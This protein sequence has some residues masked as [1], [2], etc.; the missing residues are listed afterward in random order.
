[1]P[2]RTDRELLTERVMPHVC[3]IVAEGG[4]VAASLRRV[5]DAAGV[6][7]SVLRN[8][9]TS[10]ETL[11]LAAALWV[12]EKL[13]NGWPF[14]ETGKDVDLHLQQILQR[15]VPRDEEQVVWARV[16]AAFAFA[17]EPGTRLGELVLS[18]HRRDG[19]ARTIA[20]WARWELAGRK[21]PGKVIL[22]GDMTP[23]DPENMDAAEL[24]LLVIVA[25][26]TSLMTRRGQPLGVEAAGEWLSHLTSRHLDL[27]P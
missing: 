5:A 7:P 24:H 8:K 4:V 2:K 18:T 22:P 13:Q 6:T 21:L 20:R 27:R 23:G 1:M 25:G 14:W 11:H 15:L 17:G 9:W 16:W 12:R 26:L 3:R 19:A 10:Q